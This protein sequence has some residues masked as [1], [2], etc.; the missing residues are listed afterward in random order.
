MDF[1]AAFPYP[2][3]LVAYSF[4]RE[5]CICPAGVILEQLAKEISCLRALAYDVTVGHLLVSGA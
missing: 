2:D 3:P 1:P 5:C 4:S